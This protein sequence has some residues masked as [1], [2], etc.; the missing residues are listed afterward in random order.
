MTV[1]D[2]D[3]HPPPDLSARKGTATDKATPYYKLDYRYM[4][5]FLSH[6]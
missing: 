4:V 1:D 3:G 6:R 2:V 5:T